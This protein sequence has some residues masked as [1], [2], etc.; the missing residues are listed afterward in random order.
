[1]STDEARR[2]IA[3]L[4]AEAAGDL[5][6]FAAIP[7][8][9]A[10][11]AHH[12]DVLQAA[13]W[14]AGRLSRAGLA[15]VEL[16]ETGGNPVV[17]A[18]M[19]PADAP[20]V[21]VYGHYDVQ[22]ADPVEAWESPPFS[23]TVTDGRLVARGASDDKGPILC[24]LV[25]I[26]ARLRLEPPR[27]VRLKFLFEGEEEIG[28]PSLPAFLQRER[29]RFRADLVL[30]AD[31]GMWRA[32]EPSLNVSS[33]GLCNVE[34]QVESA[35]GDLHSGRHGGAV[36]NALHALAELLAGLHDAGGRVTV[37]GFYDG[38]TT[39]TSAQRAEIAAL[40][41]DE[42]AYRREVGAERLVGE[43]G[44]TTLERM[45]LR[46][47]LD[48]VGMWGGF[49]E[50]GMK[51]VIPARAHAKLSCRLV[52]DQDPAAVQ[53]LLI[54]HLEAQRPAGARVRARPVPG[55]ARPYSLP[56]GYPPLG[57]AATVLERAL[58]GRTLLVRMGGTLPAAEL[59][60]RELGAE[61]MFFSFSVADEHY[62]APGEFFRLD[63]IEPGARAW[64]DL[65]GA[66]GPA[67]RS[68]SAG[69]ARPDGG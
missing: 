11:S 57:L 17:T 43:A 55:L 4:A 29:E 20:V 22:P 51:T 28:S 41:F 56:E 52:P 69:S 40:P 47:T 31:G 60:R 64:F 65:I 25:G 14:L 1:V 7:S 2:E 44:Y 8:V 62:H 12:A 10:L 50:E 36:P 37:P 27:D 35:S 49:T 61:T 3:R 53:R 13:A 32:G 19:G 26:E 48:A 66:I 54:A 38:V 34:V 9:S 68:G 5:G 59:F 63:R 21:L 6:T 30:S 23:P 15:G 39:P 24:A 42:E 58:G 46:P 33:K 16:L 18:D 67:L 45:W